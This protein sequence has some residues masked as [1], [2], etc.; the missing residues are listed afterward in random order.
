MALYLGLDFETFS[1]VDITKVGLDNYINHPDFEPLLGAIAWRET[2]SSEISTRLYDFVRLRWPFSGFP[3][4]LKLLVK[5][6]RTL[7]AH[8]SMFEKLVLNRRSE[9][10]ESGLAT[11]D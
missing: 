9:S 7:A 10:L 11:V 3:E 1:G 4:D 5:D 8:N 6:G 2:P